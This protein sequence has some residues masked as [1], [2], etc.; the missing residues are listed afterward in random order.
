MAAGQSVWLRRPRFPKF[1][2]LI[3][4]NMNVDAIRS[5]PAMK[6]LDA[7]LAGEVT[8]NNIAFAVAAK[9]VKVNKEVAETMI[10]LLQTATQIPA[11]A[12]GRGIDITA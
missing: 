1:T 9:Q 2:G 4:G 6:Q 5:T 12:S 7:A 11:K 10:D 8:K 3:E